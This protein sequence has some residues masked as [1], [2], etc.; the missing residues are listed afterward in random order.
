[1]VQNCQFRVRA[2][3]SDSKIIGKAIKGNETL[4]TIRI[5]A[6]NVRGTGSNGAKLRQFH[7]R[8]L[9]PEGAEA[10]SPGWSEAEPGEGSN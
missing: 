8:I 10:L 9:R 5:I 2:R 4:Y 7:G 6:N 3:S 1:M